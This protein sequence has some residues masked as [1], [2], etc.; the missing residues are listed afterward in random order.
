MTCSILHI[1][2]QPAGAALDRFGTALEAAIADQSI[3]PYFGIGFETIAQ[4]NQVFTPERWQLIEVL[5]AAGPL[6]I[7][8]LTQHLGRHYPTVYQD[9]TT[10]IEWTVIDQDEEGRVFVPWD[11]IDM[12]WPLMRR[13]A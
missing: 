8:M 4:L 10:L 3:E 2:I 13:A 12:H 11:E 1:E 6:T 9:V 7:D 5:K